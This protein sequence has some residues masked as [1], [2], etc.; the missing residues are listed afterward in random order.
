MSEEEEHLGRLAYEEY[1]RVHSREDK[2]YVPRIWEMWKHTNRPEYKA[3][4][5]VG[6][7]VATQVL[8]ELQAANEASG[9]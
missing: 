6:K 7:A 3:W 4:C 2:A 5:A 1:E 9:A 8:Q